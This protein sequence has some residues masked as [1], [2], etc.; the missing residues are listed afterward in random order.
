L[1]EPS[2]PRLLNL[3]RQTR[4][5]IYRAECGFIRQ[6]RTLR[7]TKRPEHVDAGIQELNFLFLS[8]KDSPGGIYLV[9]VPHEVTFQQSDFLSVTGVYLRR[10]PYQKPS[11]AW[12]W[13]PWIV[14]SKVEKIELTG[15]KGWGAFIFVLLALGAV[16]AVALFFAARREWSELTSTRDHLHARRRGGRNMIRRKVAGAMAASSDGA[17]PADGDQP[18]SASKGGPET[19]DTPDPAPPAADGDEEKG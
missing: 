10:W 6:Y 19:K 11:G 4:G 2:Y 14:A 17:K 7:L 15:A 1:E 13:I 9:S 8:A 12:K 16:G 3:P 18:G 5:R